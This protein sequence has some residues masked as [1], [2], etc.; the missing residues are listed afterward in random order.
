MLWVY[1]DVLGLICHFF[2][3][4]RSE[5]HIKKLF[6]SLSLTASILFFCHIRRHQ[7]LCAETFIFRLNRNYYV[8]MDTVSR[9]DTSSVPFRWKFWSLFVCRLEH[10]DR[11]IIPSS[12]S[13]ERKRAR[14]SEQSWLQGSPLISDYVIDLACVHVCGRQEGKDLSPQRESESEGQCKCYCSVSSFDQS[15]WKVKRIQSGLVCLRVGGVYVYEGSGERERGLSYSRWN[16]G[17]GAERF[18][19]SLMRLDSNWP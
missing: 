2:H 5:R 14:E 3:F 18:F 17:C 11:F 15:H 8:F 1:S 9:L 6:F 10:S 13:N 7:I 19:L 4:C 16:A 12:P